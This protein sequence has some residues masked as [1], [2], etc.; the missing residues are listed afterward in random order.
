MVIRTGKFGEFMACSNFPKC[1]NIKS[2]NKTV[3]KC[4][5]C[6]S[7]VVERTSKKGDKYFVCV[8]RPD[9][10][11]FWSWELPSNDKCEKCGSYMTEK[12]VYG[13]LRKKCANPECNH[14]VNI[15]VSNTDNMEGK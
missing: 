8:S 7:E 4:P 15:S 3:A 1:R 5:K 9:S 11:D 14:V 6:G 10:C 2:I 12:I 13:K